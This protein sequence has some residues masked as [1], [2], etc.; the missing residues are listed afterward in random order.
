MIVMLDGDAVRAVLTPERALTA[1]REAMASLS[2]GHALTPLRQ[3]LPLGEG[4]YLGLMPGADADLPVYG[5]KLVT[6]HAANAARGLPTIQGLIVLFD[7]QTGAPRALVDGAEVTAIRTAAA[8][9]L[10]TDL[11]ARTDA[12]SHGVFGAGV[13]ARTHAIAI[14]AAR[15]AI[16]TLRIWSRDRAQAQRLAEELGDEL[17]LEAAAAPA[18]AAAACDVVSTVTASATPVLKGAWLT[19]GAHLNLVGAH[20]PDK[21][22]TDTAA[23]RRTRVFVDSLE[24]ARRE[25]GD[26]L[27]PVSEGAF[28]FEDVAA[29]IGAVV[30]G[31]RPGR[32]AADEITLYKSL[33]LAVQDLHAAWACACAHADGAGGSA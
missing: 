21:R 17:G 4:G 18:E 10:A 9:A 7:R 22:E 24:A 14:A 33:G 32:T 20:S 15:P 13:Q 8:S 2:R 19:P 11:L 29:E 12:Q 1:M 28:T 3:M 31:A 26:L 5:V 25:A 30:T 6:L 27:I 16:R 23:I